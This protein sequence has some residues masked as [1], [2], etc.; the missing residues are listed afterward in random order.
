MEG[1]VKKREGNTQCV[2]L[3]I[4]VMMMIMMVARYERILINIGYM[5]SEI[6]TGV[7]HVVKNV[8][9]NTHEQR[10]LAELQLITGG[11][12]DN[13]SNEEEEEV[14]EKRVVVV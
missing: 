14:E 2:V 9:M 10:R 8:L 5:P 11:D 3:L 7:V 12:N 6:T 4:V 1:N 13:N